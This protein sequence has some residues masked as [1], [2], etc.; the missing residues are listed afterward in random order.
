VQEETEIFY[1]D[2]KYYSEQFGISME[3]AGKEAFLN[4]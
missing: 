3:Q 2:D 1:L 4:A